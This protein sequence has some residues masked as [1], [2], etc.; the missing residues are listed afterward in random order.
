M[1][2]DPPLRPDLPDPAFAAAWYGGAP[3]GGFAAGT[4]L[5]TADGPVAVEHL[6]PGDRLAGRG[7]GSVRLRHVARCDDPG[8]PA[9]GRRGGVVLLPPDAL[10][11]GRPRRALR[12]EARQAVW[13]AG[14]AGHYRVAAGGL[15]CGAGVRRVAEA[16]PLHMLLAT[17][18]D[19][20][21]AEGLA[22]ALRPPTRPEHD[23]RT[24]AALAA[25]RLAQLRAAPPLGPRP[26]DG[27][28][29]LDSRGW[30]RG[31]AID[32]AAPE[33]PV[34]LE[35]LADDLTLGFALADEARPDL[36]M[37]GLGACGFALAL[38]A[39]GPA[40]SVILLTI[41]AVG[42]GAALPGTPLLV[43]PPGA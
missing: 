30:L 7:G 29:T 10:G 24:G 36:A 15:C 13:L 40:P 19:V 35:V 3:A 26:V 37:A 1:A 22:C 14:A 41:Q 6:R 34:L 9:D 11:P 21:L 12:L 39:G 5:E 16:P 17:G 2:D 23:R 43:A 28:V 42:S 31:W 8:G 18:D 4:L 27:A 25:A 20:V 32:R 33:V 38:P